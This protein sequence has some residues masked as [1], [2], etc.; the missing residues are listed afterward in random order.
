MAF[1]VDWARQGTQRGGGV[2]RAD[3]VP[4][5]PPLGHP[6]LVAPAPSGKLLAFSG[7][8]VNQ[9]AAVL[10]HWQIQWLY[11]PAWFVSWGN[12]L[13]SHG[14]TG[15]AAGQGSPGMQWVDIGRHCL[16]FCAEVLGPVGKA[17]LRQGVWQF[18]ASPGL[19]VRATDDGGLALRGA[20]LADGWWRFHH[21]EPFAGDGGWLSLPREWP[22]EE[23]ME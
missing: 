13:V 19:A 6:A 18:T 22:F 9:A 14:R 3:L 20:A 1:R 15:F 4:E 21:I 17:E 16:L 2:G 7:R 12:G 23:E 10:A 5:R 11:H 8:A